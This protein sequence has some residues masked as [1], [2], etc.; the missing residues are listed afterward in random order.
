M[1][2]SDAAGVLGEL[3]NCEPSQR[4]VP[5]HGLGVPGPLLQS[6]VPAGL[7]GSRTGRSGWK[8]RERGGGRGRSPL[9]LGSSR[10][11]G[12]PVPRQLFVQ[13]V[14]ASADPALPALIN[15]AVAA[16][17]SSPWGSWLPTASVSLFPSPFSF[18]FAFPFLFLLT[19][20]FSFSFLFPFSF[21]FLLSFLFSLPFPFYF[22]LPSPFHFPFPSPFTFLFSFPCLSYS[23]LPLS[24]SF[25]FPSLF[26]F[27]VPF[28]PS[29]S[30]VES[31]LDGPQDCA[32]LG[33]PLHYSLAAPRREVGTGRRARHRVG[34]T[35][36]A[37]SSTR[38]PPSEPHQGLGR[39]WWPQ[40]SSGRTCG[41]CPCIPALL[42]PGPCPCSL[43]ALEGGLPPTCGRQVCSCFQG[44]EGNLGPSPEAK[45]KQIRAGFRGEVLSHA[46]AHKQGAWGAVVVP[47]QGVQV[48]KGI[49]RNGQALRAA[50]R[51]CSFSPLSFSSG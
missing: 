22:P 26:A 30:R 44:W 42:P 47:H 14:L 48:E 46:Q 10:I 34:S 51:S 1:L 38:S 36:M 8:C 9:C 3:P 40:L 50:G 35:V 39:G 31:R 41:M 37:S 13:P 2:C 19:F 6:S 21:P 43:P 24:F 16:T 27:P 32:K 12:G 49:P 33:H 5:S 23:L 4:A 29:P 25:P 11:L 15:H 20:S 7:G 28:F 45:Q 17:P 18:L